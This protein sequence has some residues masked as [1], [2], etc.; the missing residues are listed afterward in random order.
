MPGF[1]ASNNRLTLLLEADAVGD[2]KLK[3]A[4]LLSENSRA[5]KN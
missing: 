5:L 3:L 2:F 4:L 1:K